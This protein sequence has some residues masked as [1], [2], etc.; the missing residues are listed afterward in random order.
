MFVGVPAMP[1]NATKI[2]QR[3]LKL[4]PSFSK[5]EDVGLLLYQKGLHFRGFVTIS[6][7][8]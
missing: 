8:S 2:L 3:H 5:V 1:M 7:T 4:K 6:E